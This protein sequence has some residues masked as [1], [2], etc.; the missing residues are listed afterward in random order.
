MNHPRV[1][2]KRLSSAEGT[3]SR[4]IYGGGGLRKTGV[5]DATRGFNQPS[6]HLSSLML[7]INEAGD[8]VPLPSLLLML[9][10]LSHALGHSEH[11]KFT[12]VQG[13]EV[14]GLVEQSQHSLSGARY[15]HSIGG[16]IILFLASTTHVEIEEI[17]KSGIGKEVITDERKKKNLLGPVVTDSQKVTMTER[18][19]VN[20]LILHITCR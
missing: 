1:R 14:W 10:F 7:E 4:T 13:K 20:T 19:T 5:A 2:T 9:F 15:S 18:S 3:V 16:T 12:E 11:Q 17:N 6:F 8:P